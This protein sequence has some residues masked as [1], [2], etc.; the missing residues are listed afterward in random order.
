MIYEFHPEAQQ[1][2]IETAA[3]YEQDV[4]S[5]GERFGSEVRRAVDRLLEYPELGTP[6]DADLRDWRMVSG[7]IYGQRKLSKRAVTS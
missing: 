5:L 1:E 7:T 6:I 4:T 3:Y 2:F